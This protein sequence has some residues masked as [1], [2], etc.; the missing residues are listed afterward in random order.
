MNDIPFLKKKFKWS[1][2]SGSYV[3]PTLIYKTKLWHSPL[4]KDPPSKK[5]L[6]TISV[7]CLKVSLDGQI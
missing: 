2:H 5:Q 4:E 1:Q 7:C 6:C 3:A